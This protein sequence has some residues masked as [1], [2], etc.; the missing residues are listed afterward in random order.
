MGETEIVIRR[1]DDWHLHVRDGE[2][3]EAVVPCSSADFGRAVIMPNTVPPV[4]TLKQARAYKKR[5]QQ[6][7]PEGHEFEPLMTLYLTELTAPAE[8]SLAADSGLICGVK[9]YPAG[10]TT[11]SESG[12]RSMDT[13]MPVLE[14]M[15]KAGLPLL[16]HG[17]VTDN[18]VDIFD[19]EAVF[20]DTVLDPL[21]KRL[22]ELRVVFEH[23]TTITGVDYVQNA[24]TG[25]AATITAHHLIINRNAYLAGGIKPH[26]YCLPV[27]KREKH[28]LALRQA[29]TSGDSRF[30]FGSDSAPHTDGSKESSCGCAGI[31]TAANAL[32]CLAAV[33]EQEGKLHNLEKFVSIHG[34]QFYGLPVNA[35]KIR[36]YTRKTPLKPAGKITT[37]EGA[38][39]VFDP[40]FPLHW[41]VDNSTDYWNKP[42]SI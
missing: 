32:V 25:L 28:R 37:T 4:T 35:T 23:L 22:P 12:V 33:F 26:Y 6:S 8:I 27:A 18:E 20:I 16:V 1:P 42:T 39:T 19:R 41:R 38:V 5:I 13:V 17:E 14:E 2:M 36:L 9:L 40:L 29:A 30:F 7:I 10:A 15:A 3:M 34:A 11:H 21:R 24:A 31:F